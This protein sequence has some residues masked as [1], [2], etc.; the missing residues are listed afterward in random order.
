MRA[1]KIAL[2]LLIASGLPGFSA[3][4]FQD[5][6]YTAGF[7][8]PGDTRIVVQ[9]VDITADVD[10]SLTLYAIA[11]RNLGT[12]SATQLWQVVISDG[13]RVLGTVV[14]PIGIESGGVIIPVSLTLPPRA[15]QRLYIQVSVAGTGAVL[16]GETIKLA[17]KFFFLS[18]NVQGESEWI[19]DAAPE[20]ILKAGFEE[21]EEVLIPAIVLNPGD[22]ATVQ[23]SLW[24]D[25]DANT[26][27]LVLRRLKLQNLGTARGSDIERVEVQ[28]TYGSFTETIS[29]TDLTGWEQSGIIYDFLRGFDIPDNSV[30]SIAV[31]AQTSLSAV[32]GST[33]RTKLV[34]ELEENAQFFE[35][36]AVSCSI[37]T[38]GVGGIDEIKDISVVPSPSVLNPG[39]ILTQII[40]LKDFDA[41][42]FDVEVTSIWI[43]NSAS[44]TALG[45]EIAAIEIFGPQG[46]IAI[47]NRP[48]VLANLHTTGIQIDLGR[49]LIIPDDHE[50]TVSIV[51]RIAQDVVEGH[52]LRPEVKVFG[53]EARGVAGWSPSVV[54]PK[55]IYLYPAGLEI[56]EDLTPRGHAVYSGQ[57]ALVQKIKLHDLDQNKFN[58][59]LN[60]LVV[61]NLGTATEGDIV[62]FEVTD[63]ENAVLAQTTD[64]RNLRTS[65]VVLSLNRNN[66][67][68]DDSEKELFFWITVAGPER[69]V[70][71]RTVQLE[72]SVFHTEGGVGFTRILRSSSVFTLENN[73]PPVVDFSWSPQT[74]MWGKSVTFTPAVSDPDGDA[75]VY[76]RWDF[77]GVLTP[78]ERDGPPQEITVSFPQEGTYT[79]TLLVRDAKGLEGQ[80]TKTLTVGWVVESLPLAGATVYSTQRF[81]AQKIRLADKD[82]DS[83]AVTLSKVKVKNTGTAADTQFVKLEV[84]QGGE[85]GA[86]LVETTNLTGFKTGLTL[87]PTAHN[88][89]PDDGA[90]EI[91][92][93]VTLAGP[94]KTEDNK[95]LTLETAFTYSEG[96]TSGDTPPLQGPSFTIRLN[97]PPVVDFSWS[98]QTPMWGKSV[99]FTPAVS[100]P[101]GDAIVYSR[102]DFGGV[103]TPVER[104]GPP[105]EITVSFPQEGTYTVTLLVR[106][107]KGLE[108]Q[109]TKTLTVGWVVESLPLAGATVYST[110]RFVAQKIR[111]ADKDADSEAVTLS[112]VKVKN[113]GTA[114]D[115]QFVKLEVRQGGENG[116]LLVETTNLTGFK[117]GLTLTPTAHN[118]VPDDGALEIWIWVTLA[119]PEKTE[120]NKTLTLETAFTYSEGRTSGDTPP[121]QGP[122]FTIRL[123]RPPVVDFS[124]SPESPTWQDTITFTPQVSDPDNDRL[125]HFEWDFGDR[126]EKVITASPQPV[127]HRYPEGGEFQVTLTV[128][129]EK[130]LVSTKTKTLNVTPRPNYPP[131][132]DFSWEPSQ[133]LVNQAVVFIPQVDDP[134]RDTPFSYRWEFGPK[135]TPSISTAE[136]PTVTF[137]EA[138]SYNVRLEVTDARGAKGTKEKTVKVGTRPVP[139]ITNV[140]ASPS[141]PAVGQSVTFIASATAPADDPVRKWKW[142]FGD[143]TSPQETEQNTITHVYR[144][145]GVFI[146]TVQAQNNAGWSAART[147]QIVIHPQGV[148]FG[149]LVLDNPVMGNQCRIQIFAPAEATD[150]KIT[151]LDIAGRPVLLD[152]PVSV[153]TFTWD[154][155]DREGRLVPNGL[156][157]FYV[158]A[159][160][161]G[162]IRRTEIGR[163]LVRR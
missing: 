153:G 132:V 46:L 55:P 109:K 26:S 144:T 34:L 63:V 22:F 12:A 87:T 23:L 140:S 41:N 1:A 135:A 139:T 84:R 112:K 89:V 54:Y 53:E 9:V 162:Q 107:A 78:V 81:V 95:T 83:E 123:N 16:G 2:G 159:R 161:E 27:F 94:E 39:E 97:R 106:D 90:L 119:G 113:T 158:T 50:I 124:W 7:L 10:E 114:A 3:P 72:V 21:I 152:K 108:G 146:V 42:L 18:G 69:H 163:I 58:V 130:G 150:L 117:T 86:L 145:A 118:V 131:T 45:R 110:Q 116:A 133:P 6:A 157:L 31:K 160:I 149:A 73:R 24:K 129:D 65:G 99:T 32:G 105:Q 77:G 122:S 19:T 92:I 43:R 57:R 125:V 88:V 64:L 134:D 33:I 70:S 148:E 75:I 76:S 85:N 142:D 29:F 25:S 38:I 151:I 51:Y 154:L 91:W 17:T 137:V 68:V 4:I 96:R 8:N 15:A 103:L 111:L 156:Y 5:R 79:V 59:L 67:I 36:T 37:F 48:D 60:P 44:A 121:L 100:D 11:L 143:G 28:L 56:V 93:W 104:D 101:D 52:S 98:P 40:S 138:G 155:K 128:K 74:P 66:L 49:S 147:I 127:Q 80:K 47:E 136:R 13:G 35:Q 126:T 14:N 62:K 71:G 120:D 102:W 115:T 30:L 20:T 61:K 141:Y 82:A